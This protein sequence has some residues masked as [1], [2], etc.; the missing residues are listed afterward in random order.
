MTNEE[1][2]AQIRQH[3]EI[4]AQKH[5]N[6]STEH[7]EWIAMIEKHQ[8]KHHTE[9]WDSKRHPGC[10]LTGTLL[11]NRVP[12]RFFIQ[13]QGGKSGRDLAPRMANLSHQVH[14]LS[15]KSAEAKDHARDTVLPVGFEE[16]THPMDGKVYATK[17]LHQAYHHYIKL[18]STN[19]H[20]YKVLENSQLVY[21]AE[22]KIPEAKFVLD[23][24]AI[25]V[26]YRTSSRPWYDYLTS[27]LAIVGG[28][29]TVVGLVDS[30]FYHAVLR[31]K[32]ALFKRPP[33]P[34]RQAP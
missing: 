14:H 16:M 5:L 32:R 13:A 8:H 11:M 27:L 34:L 33:P 30:L 31:S 6:M 1:A 19:S 17:H 7:K 20:F 23:I 4:A 18:V 22:D 12:G 2:V 21:Y 29:F 28:T 15:F 24:S 9:T 3:A 10:L 25:A 26:H